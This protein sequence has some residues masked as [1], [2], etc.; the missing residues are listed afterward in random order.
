[1]FELGSLALDFP[2]V[3]LDLLILFRRLV[4]TALQLV[5]HERARPESKDGSDGRPRAR[6]TDRGSDDA[7]RRCAAQS[8]DTSSLF[9]GGQRSAG[10]SRQQ[11][12]DHRNRRDESAPSFTD[13]HL[14]I[15]LVD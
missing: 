12:R 8:A 14:S 7:A 6:V 9:T 11:R 5:T 3:A 10:T 4:V 13:I 1:L 15:L 2:L